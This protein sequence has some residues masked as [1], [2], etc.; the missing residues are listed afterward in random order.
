MSKY[1]LCKSRTRHYITR[2]GVFFWIVGVKNAW[3]TRRGQQLHQDF[4]NRLLS[5][6]RSLLFLPR[7]VRDTFLPCEIHTFGPSSTS[8]RR[9]KGEEGDDERV[10]VDWPKSS[11][12][13]FAPPPSIYSSLVSAFIV[14]DFVR[15]IE[16]CPRI[17]QRDSREHCHDPGFNERSFLFLYT[18]GIHSYTPWRRNINFVTEIRE[19]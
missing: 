17:F 8:V 19:K 18:R 11:S 4:R 9:G 5:C 2:P 15:F 13:R 12:S 1:S 7:S 16:A 3:R 6:Y 10:F 14:V